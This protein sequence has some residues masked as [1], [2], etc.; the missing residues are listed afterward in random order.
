MA[1]KQTIEQLYTVG[2]VAKM[3]AMSK[4]TIYDWCGKGLVKSLKIGKLV[5]IPHSEVLR[6][7]RGQSSS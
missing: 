7:Q 5:R 3:L 6:L 4:F 2:E 1:K